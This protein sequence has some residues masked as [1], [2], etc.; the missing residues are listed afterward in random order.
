MVSLV[1]IGPEAHCK[2]RNADRIADEQIAFDIGAY[3]EQIR[4]IRLSA[5]D[6][7]ERDQR[8]LNGKH[9]GATFSSRRPTWPCVEMQPT[10]RGG[11]RESGGCPSPSHLLRSFRDLKH[12]QEQVAF[13]S[14][15]RAAVLAAQKA[16]PFAD[17]PTERWI[18]AR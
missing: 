5:E 3:E 4:A 16:E 9:S 18:V 13:E 6:K 15:Q 8:A 7:L 2:R 1:S 11:R 14:A 10:H 12:K 17:Y